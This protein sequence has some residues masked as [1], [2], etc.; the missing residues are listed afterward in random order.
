MEQAT[1]SEYINKYSIMSKEAFKELILKGKLKTRYEIVYFILNTL[2]YIKKSSF[3]Y[4]YCDHLENG[5]K[6]KMCYISIIFND[7]EKDIKR[8]LFDVNFLFNYYTKLCHEL[9]ELF[10]QKKKIVL[11]AF[12]V[13]TSLVVETGTLVSVTLSESIRYNERLQVACLKR[14]KL[15]I[16][17]EF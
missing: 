8:N 5:D 9:L 17:A 10:D 12:R 15:P 7:F 13:S 1:T 6:Y 2:H 4:C 16:P 11:N 3:W 14:Q